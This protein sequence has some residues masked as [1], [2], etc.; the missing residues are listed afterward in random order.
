L[1]SVVS[2]TP[3]AQA[4]APAAVVQ[5]PS[6]VG[7]WPVTVGTACPLATFATHAAV[8][9]SQYCVAL[10]SASTAQPVVE[11]QTPPVG[12]QSP[13]RQTVAPFVAV[14]GPSPL[15]YPHSLSFVSHTPLVHTRVPAAAVH[16]PSSVGLVCAP[17]TGTAVPLASCP[18]QMCVVSS[19]QLPAVQSASTLQ[20]PLGSHVPLVLHAPERQTV[21]PVTAVQGPSPLA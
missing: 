3:L 15:A 8:G 1:L 19:H 7:L 14:Q 10:Q 5:V 9:V 21:A 6:S 12:L 20:P 16:V 13:E 11:M 18:V 17:S 2:H 4:A